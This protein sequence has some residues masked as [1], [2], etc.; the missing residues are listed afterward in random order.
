MLYVHVFVRLRSRLRVCVCVFVV[1]VLSCLFLLFI[2]SLCLS[3]FS[4]VHFVFNRLR[5]CVPGIYF[6]GSLVCSLE[7]SCVNERVSVL[8]CL[9]ACLS[10]RVRMCVCLLLSV[11]CSFPLSSFYI[12][13]KLF[14]MVLA[15]LGVS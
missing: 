7:C 2:S 4:G 12:V 10:I 6:V 15:W 3:V 13:F 14:L 11:V 9:I 8:V 1:R 5:V